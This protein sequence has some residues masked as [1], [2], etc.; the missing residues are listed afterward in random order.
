MPG[1]RKEY[2]TWDEYFMANAILIS[3]RSK[4]PSNQVGACIV[5]RDNKVLS[6]GYNGLTSGMNDDE[7][8]WNSIGEK[9]GELDK[10]KDYFVVHA[11]RNAIL[12]YRGSLADFE[13]STLY[14]TWFPC[15]ECTKEIIQV[16]IKKIIY[17]R[18]YSKIELVKLSLQML[19]KAGVEVVAYNDIKDFTR[20]EIQKDTNNIQKIIK[21]YSVYKKN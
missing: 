11:E 20:E 10:I 14:V 21:R 1:K 4:D 8:Y 13:G 12:N 3:A 16:G 9:T 17:L 19:D 6:V 2:L 15:V 5:T 7:F 18:M